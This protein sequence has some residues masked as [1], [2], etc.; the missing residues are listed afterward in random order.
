MINGTQAKALAKEQLRGEFLMLCLI[1]LLPTL[2]S[3]LLTSLTAGIGSVVAY[4][5][6]PMVSLGVTLVF[7][8]R[9]NQIE[10]TLAQVFSYHTLW[11]KAFVT[12]FLVSVRVCL[13]SLLFIIPGIIEGARCSM[14]FY[15]LAENP[16]LS[17]S[18]AIALSV[19]MTR[20]KLWDLIVFEL[21]FIGWYCLIALSAGIVS[22]WV[23]PY[24][25]AA[26]TN[27]YLTLKQGYRNAYHG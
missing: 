24:H 11:W 26:F 8:N 9:A 13:W 14:A 3:T 5:G 20:G 19:D 22:I 17:A 21:S 16:D 7:L 2:L 25:T 4:L 18:E 10:Y 15:I 23:M 12:F 6:A 27:V 1:S